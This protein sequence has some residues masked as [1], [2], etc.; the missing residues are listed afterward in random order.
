MCYINMMNRPS[1]EK[2]HHMDIENKSQR[3]A[4]ESSNALENVLFSPNCHFYSPYYRQITMGS[5]TQI[6]EEVEDDTVQRR[7]IL[8]QL[9][10]TI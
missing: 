8:L 2:K 9:L 6:Q 4:V 5:W 1:A 3:K 7:K 10:A